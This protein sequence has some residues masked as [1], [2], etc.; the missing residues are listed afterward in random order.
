MFNLVSLQKPGKYIGNYGGGGVSLS[1]L[2]TAGGANGLR[3]KEEGFSNGSYYSEARCL[4]FPFRL[5]C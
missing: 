2:R 1:F 4:E 3:G 5:H